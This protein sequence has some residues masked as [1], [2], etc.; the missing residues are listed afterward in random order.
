MK[1]FI[2]RKSIVE[3]KV[4]DLYMFLSDLHKV[5]TRQSLNDKPNSRTDQYDMDL[6]RLFTSSPMITEYVSSYQ[7]G[8][9]YKAESEVSCNH[10]ILL[11]GHYSSR[12]VMTHIRTNLKELLKMVQPLLQSVSFMEMMSRS[13]LVRFQ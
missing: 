10:F 1:K 12:M 6:E 9:M 8:E 5:I 7:I 3:K 11:I 13:H 2:I 4:F